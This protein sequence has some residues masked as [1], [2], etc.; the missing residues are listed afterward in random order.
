MEQVVDA[1]HDQW[2]RVVHHLDDALDAQ[3]VLALKRGDQAEPAGQGGERHRPV[4]IGVQG[5]ADCFQKLRLPYESAAARQLNKDIFETIY[6]GAVESSAEL[7]AIDGAYETWEGSPA[8]Q[9]KL[10][11]DLWGVTPSDRWDWATLKAK[12]AATGLRNSLLMAPMPT[13]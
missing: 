1:V 6:F 5:L 4:G 9:G 2:A 12:I 13:A 10:Q 11:Y 8:H 3:D 7:A